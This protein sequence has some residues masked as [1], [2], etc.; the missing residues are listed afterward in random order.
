MKM[1]E[2]PSTSAHASANDRKNRV[3]RRHVS[4]RY[5]FVDNA[6]LRHVD[7]GGE[8]GPAKYA[9][10]DVGDDVLDYFVA[11]RDLSRRCELRGM[12]LAVSK[13]ERMN[14]ITFAARESEQGR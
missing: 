1:S 13:A 10:V 11:S 4:H 2:A 3:S 14:C 9:K 8:R 7:V 12:A 5:R 6:I